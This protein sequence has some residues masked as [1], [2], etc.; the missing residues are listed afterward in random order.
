MEPTEDVD[1]Q[2]YE[3]YLPLQIF[4]GGGMPSEQTPIVKEEMIV[5]GEDPLGICEWIH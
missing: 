5:E 3:Q 4:V 1:S 2:I